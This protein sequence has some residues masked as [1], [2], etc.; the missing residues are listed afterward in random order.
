M[1]Q[2]NSAFAAPDQLKVNNL[3]V[4][5]E[6]RT[7]LNSVTV[8]FQRGQLAF[9]LGPNGAG[10]STLM[11]CLAGLESPS[12]E[13]ARRIAWV[14]TENQVAFAFTAREVVVMGRFP[15]HQGS[16]CAVDLARADS[17]LRAVGAMHF[18][19]APMPLLSSGERQRVHIARALAS[20][21][22]FLLLDEPF[23]NLD[24]AASY[25]IMDLLRTEVSAGRGVIVCTHDLAM[26]WTAGDYLICLHRGEV[27]ASGQPKVALSADVLAEVFGLR[28]QIVSDEEGNKRLLLDPI[29]ATARDAP[30]NVRRF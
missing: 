7:I 12:L 26:A 16:P 30:A 19:E 6:R 25:T 24:L 4:V 11:S 3:A 21:A 9:L 22:P 17:A 2:V 27:I 10:K 18:A 1:N 20:D 29:S 14:P 23:A 5:R 28:S 15:W 13:Q 8:C